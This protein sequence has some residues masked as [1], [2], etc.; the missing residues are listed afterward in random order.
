MIIVRS[1]L[2]MMLLHFWLMLQDA[3]TFLFLRGYRTN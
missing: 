1:E 2:E 3:H